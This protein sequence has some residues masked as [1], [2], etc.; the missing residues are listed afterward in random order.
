MAG[1]VVGGD[2]FGLWWWWLVV[3]VRLVVVVARLVGWSFRYP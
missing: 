2:S 3:V 1:L